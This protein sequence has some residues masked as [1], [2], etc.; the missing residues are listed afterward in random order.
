[1][2]EKP[3]RKEP[4]TAQTFDEDEYKSNLIDNEEYSEETAA[5]KARKKKEQLE[6]QAEKGPVIKMIEIDLNEITFVKAQREKMV[7]VRRGGKTFKRK[8]KVG[9]KDGSEQLM[10]GFPGIMSEATKFNSRREFMS[11]V[12]TAWTTGKMIN[13]G[14][15]QGVAFGNTLLTT[16][17]LERI[18]SNHPQSKLLEYGKK[19]S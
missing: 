10:V 11:A 9:K 19:S 3:G 17:I 4:E 16:D 6:T 5:V 7:T 8:Q 2:P 14:D 13:V 18:K 1:M 12:K 15:E